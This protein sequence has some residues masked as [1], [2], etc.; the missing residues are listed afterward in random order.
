MPRTPRHRFRPIAIAIAGHAPIEAYPRRVTHEYT[1]L[2]GGTIVPGDGA[3]DATAIA[4]AAGVI[5]AL[6][7][8]ATAGDPGAA[9]GVGP[10]TATIRGGH[11]VAGAFPGL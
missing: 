8:D 11:L 9:G 2:V 5:L 1:L 10:A 4:W 7:T 6:G 3:P